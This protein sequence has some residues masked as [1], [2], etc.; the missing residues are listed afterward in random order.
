MCLCVCVFACGRMYEK[1]VCMCELPN[2][3]EMEMLGMDR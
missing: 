2:M 1:E 3:D